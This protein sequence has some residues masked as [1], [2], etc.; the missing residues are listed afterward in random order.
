MRYGPVRNVKRHE[1]LH[2][3]VKK[4]FSAFTLF[5]LYAFFATTV[6]QR[7][8]PSNYFVRDVVDLFLLWIVRY[9]DLRDMSASW[10]VPMSVF[11]RIQ[12]L[13]VERVHPLTMDWIN[14][15]TLGI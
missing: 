11:V 13:L 15:G 5:T 12:T 7:E 14:G 3:K 2:K 1:K 10:G 8:I 9:P 6:D 4:L